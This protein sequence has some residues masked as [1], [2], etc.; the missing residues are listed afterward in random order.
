MAPSRQQSV[1]LG[2]AAA[3]SAGVGLGY[4]AYTQI[5]KRLPRWRRQQELLQQVND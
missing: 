5:N 1:A 4:V 3:V 2:L